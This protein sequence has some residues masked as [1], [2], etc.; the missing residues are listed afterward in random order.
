[1]FKLIDVVVID[2]NKEEV[3]WESF[4]DNGDPKELTEIMNCN[5]IDM[6]KLGGDVIM[7]VD[8]EGLL[9]QEN[10]YFYFKDLPFSTFAG[11]CVIAR[12]DN[13]GNTLTFNRD[14]DDVR[15]MIKWKPKGYKEEPFMAFVPL[16]DGVMH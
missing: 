10:R 6:V 9:A 4:N 12:T 3:R 7:F 15:E 16:D 8:D 1:M 14:I 13:N 2:P 11:T 5:T